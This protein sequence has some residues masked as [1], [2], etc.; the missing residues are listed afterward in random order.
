MFDY[1]NKIKNANKL[2]KFFGEFPS[3]HDSEIVEVKL[4]RRLPSLEI[5]IYTFLMQNEVDKKGHYKRDKECIVVIKF[6]S[7]ENLQIEDFN[8]QNVISNID[9]AQKGNCVQVN[10]NPCYGFAAQ[11]ACKTIEIVSIKAK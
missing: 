2:I 8:R 7:I 10:I 6:S 11:F 1:G 4:D 9:F 5:K 3:F